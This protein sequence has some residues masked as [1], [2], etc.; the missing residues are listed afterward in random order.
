FQRI[1]QIHEFSQA[2]P[3]D[4]QQFGAVRLRINCRGA[5]GPDE[6]GD[7]AEETALRYGF[8]ANSRDIL[9]KNPLFP[10]LPHLRLL[11]IFRFA[12][13]RPKW[14]EQAETPLASRLPPSQ[15]GSGDR[16][17]TQHHPGAAGNNPEGRGPVITDAQHD[18]P[19]AVLPQPGVLSDRFT[20]DLF[21]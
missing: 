8:S 2:L 21:G 20:H 14:G 5:R 10:E 6:G 19:P 16:V 18:F 1:V 3:A 7:F 17:F 4:L 15:R 9:E 13:V 12:P 11:E